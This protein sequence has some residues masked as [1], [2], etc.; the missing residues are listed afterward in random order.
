MT[1]SGTY[2]VITQQENVLTVEFDIEW[3]G[4]GMESATIHV[5]KDSLDIDS[6]SPFGGKWRRK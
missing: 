2:R 3:M 6:R 4:M 1:I 5:G